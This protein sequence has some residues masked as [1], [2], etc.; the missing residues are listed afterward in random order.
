[1]EGWV[2]EGDFALKETDE[3]D[4]ASVSDKIE[5]G[6]H[7]AGV[8]GSVENEVGEVASA[9]VEEGGVALGLGRLFALGRLEGLTPT[10]GFWVYDEGALDAE[11]FAG[12][13]EAV[14]TEVGDDDVFGDV[15]EGHSQMTM[16]IIPKPKK[17]HCD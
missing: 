1:M 11:G 14:F 6:V 7:G 9:G 5:G 4:G 2:V 17:Q 8:A 3:D 13:G 12:E 16:V 15:A 10:F